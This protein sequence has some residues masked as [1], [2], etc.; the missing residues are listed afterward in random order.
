MNIN[1]NKNN[2]FKIVWSIKIKKKINKFYVI[3][4]YKEQIRTLILT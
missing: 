1:F 3:L 2:K 4:P